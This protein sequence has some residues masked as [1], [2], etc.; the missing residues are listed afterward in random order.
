MVIDPVLSFRA[1]D[2]SEMT[3]MLHEDSEE[4]SRN[5]ILE[6]D[7]PYWGRYI[8]WIWIVFKG[9]WGK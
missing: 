4:D 1:E 6:L 2:S 9:I 7:E 5:L 8:I 3:K